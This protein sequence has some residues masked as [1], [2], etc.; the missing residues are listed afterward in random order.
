MHQEKLHFIAGFLLEK[1][2]IKMEKCNKKSRSEDAYE[3]AAQWPISML[4]TT[5][6]VLI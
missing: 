2:N 5:G 3:Q 1:N 4:N 6:D